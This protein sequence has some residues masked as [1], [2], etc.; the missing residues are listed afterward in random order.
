MD[1]GRL[2]TRAWRIIRD[3]P[4]LILLG[5]VMALSS[6]AGNGLSAARGAGIGSD[7]AGRGFGAP[8]G[9]MGAPEVAIMALV[10]LL[11][12]LAIVVAIALWAA[13]TIA[14][15][16]L[17]ASVDALE[18]GRPSRFSSA[19][20][21]GWQKG[22]RLIGI[23]VIPAIPMLVLVIIG[24][25]VF[26][27][28]AGLSGATRPGVAIPAVGGLVALGLSMLCLALPITIV[29]N[30]FRDL[31]DRAC[32]LENLGVV[33]SYRRAWEV[34]SGNLGEVIIIFVIQVAISIGIGLLLIFPGFLL[35]L[36][37][38]LW[39]VLLGVR[40][41]VVTYISTMW[42]LAWREWT[43]AESAPEL[44]IEAAPPA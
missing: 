10:A 12:G 11:I 18:S 7:S 41:A 16:G 6:G 27:L 42:T 8:S 17:I 25:V 24:I 20:L 9:P 19:W 28:V 32:M 33:D 26:A 1:Y 30:L 2:L 3:Q 35:A 40:G 15:G 13:S 23:G 36:C 31:A 37:C 34:L 43:G 22:W 29:L 4:F 14:R 21:A 5:V 38:L 39:P 44:V